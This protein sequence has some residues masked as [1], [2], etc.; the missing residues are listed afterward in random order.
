V[1]NLRLRAT[2]ARR[3]PTLT[4]SGLV[5]I[6][7]LL[8]VATVSI[9]GGSVP[10]NA[11]PASAPSVDFQG[12]NSYP[13][14]HWI[15][16][17]STPVARQ[18]FVGPD[19][20]SIDVTIPTS[21][22]IGDQCD[23]TN[24]TTG[25]E[26]WEAEFGGGWM[27][28]GGKGEREFTAEIPSGSIRPTTSDR[29]TMSC[30]SGFY[31]DS[32][33]TWNLGVKLDAP[34]TVVLEPDTTK[35]VDRY[36]IFTFAGDIYEGDADL[37]TTGTD[38][39]VRAGDRVRLYTDAGTW[40]QS[41]PAPTLSVTLSNGTTTR[42]ALDIVVT[43][44]GS[45]IGFTI[46]SDL[47]SSFAGYVYIDA[48]STTVVP[49]TST[50]AKTTSGATWDDRVI[51]SSTPAPKTLTTAPIPTITGTAKVGSTLTADTAAW[52]PAPVTLKYQWKRGSASIS[53]ATAKTYKLTAADMNASVTVSV[54]GTKT[55]YTSLT[56]TSAAKTIAPNTLTETPKPTI[57]GTAKAGS[58]LKATVGTWSPSP[59]TLG[60]QWK[61]EGVAIV[62]ATSATYKLVTADKGKN[63][64]FTVTGTKP[65]Y[66]TV[67]KSSNPKL[68]SK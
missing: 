10:A 33:V 1:N 3:R 25:E 55:G 37:A 58:T 40:R 29:Y 31:R 54:T 43:A 49:G 27:G 60:Y 52:A 17:A 5:A 47:P 51:Y 66:T 30:I 44:D 24:T 56:R 15:Y 65:G 28:E 20:T 68:I 13:I 50:T 63:I 53:G 61:R 62:G 23:F 36:R 42:K 21:M 41:A 6:A 57:A 46:P 7:T 2:T 32:V 11:V 67:I 18:L 48:R 34:E 19:T 8:G 12:P 4:R 26:P 64:T 22:G 9:G 59:V 16:G 45:I 35:L 38:Q 39:T 14:Q